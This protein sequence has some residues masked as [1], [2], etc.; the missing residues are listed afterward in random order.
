M[1]LGFLLTLWLFTWFEYL[2]CGLSVVGIALM[3]A[4]AVW[5]FLL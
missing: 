4:F 2:A 5:L 1:R 3:T